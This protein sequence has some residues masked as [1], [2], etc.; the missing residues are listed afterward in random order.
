MKQINKSIS[1]PN[2]MI[3]SGNGSNLGKTSFVCGVISSISKLLP[4]NA[5]KV[6]PHFHPVDD[7]DVIFQN[8][9]FIIRKEED[10]DG[11]KDSSRMLQAG[12]EEVYY[13]EVKDDQLR[14][15]ITELHK[16][17][18]LQGPLICESGGMRSIFKPS[19]FCVVNRT[20]RDKQKEGFTK[21]ATLADRIIIFD[22]KYFDFPPEEILFTKGKWIIR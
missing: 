4:L 20:D 5:I 14:S 11:S 15:A 2:M 17:A 10:V 18:D 7:E 13:I 16:H 19:L 8:E 21:L 6:S 3:V 22:G 9:H 12:A 1:L